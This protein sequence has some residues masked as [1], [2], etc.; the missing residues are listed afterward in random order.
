PMA[1]PERLRCRHRRV[2]DQAATV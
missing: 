2:Q 1:A